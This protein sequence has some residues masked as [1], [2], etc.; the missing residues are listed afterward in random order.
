MQKYRLGQQA[1]SQNTV[2]QNKAGNGESINISH[3]FFQCFH[4]Q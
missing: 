1:R 2:E 3:E 4:R